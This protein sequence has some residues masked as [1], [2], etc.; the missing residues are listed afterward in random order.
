MIKE[1]KEVSEVREMPLEILYYILSFLE[2]TKDLLSAQ[3]VNKTWYGLIR[4]DERLLSKFV[5]KYIN[6]ILKDYGLSYSIPVENKKNY[7]R[8][9]AKAKTLNELTKNPMVSRA[10]ITFE[11][12]FEARCIF[13]SIRSAIPA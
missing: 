6:K 3:K 4:G 8:M 12:Q 5:D 2:N 1:K 9:V 11:K 13:Q 10:E 7:L